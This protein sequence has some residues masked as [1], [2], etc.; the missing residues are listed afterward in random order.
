MS[1]ERLTYSLCQSQHRKT[2]A[3]ALRL[4][5]AEPRLSQEARPSLVRVPTLLARRETVREPP[6]SMPVS[7]YSRIT[8]GVVG[9]TCTHTLST[10]Q[11][12]T[13]TTSRSSRMTG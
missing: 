1:P 10:G 9:R 7:M 13:D 5:R 8:E 2:Q 12:R 11:K 6:L 4:G 3:A